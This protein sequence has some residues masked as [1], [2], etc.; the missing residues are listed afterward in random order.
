MNTVTI[1]E[2]QAKLPAIIDKLAPGEELIITRND[3]PIAT[4]QIGCIAL[5]WT[6]M[7]QPRRL[8]PRLLYPLLNLEAF[9]LI[10]LKSRLAGGENHLLDV[11]LILLNGL[12]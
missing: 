3:Q 1:E 8:L 2:T 4:L 7:L 12:Q 9:V 10:H 6:D 5:L 11:V